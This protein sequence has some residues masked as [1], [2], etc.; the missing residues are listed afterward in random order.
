M[1]LTPQHT[2]PK[3]AYDDGYRAGKLGRSTWACPLTEEI[4]DSLPEEDAIVAKDL[5]TAWLHG[6]RNGWRHYQRLAGGTGRLSKRTIGPR[7]GRDRAS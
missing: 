1:P 3:T 6:H 7:G 2:D 5:R 4:I